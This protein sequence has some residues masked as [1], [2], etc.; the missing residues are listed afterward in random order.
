MSYIVVGVISPMMLQ[1]WDSTSILCFGS[2]VTNF[3]DY[4]SARCAIRRTLRYS[5]RHK[6]GWEE[7][8]KMRPMAIKEYA[9]D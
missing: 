1:H 5:K 4:E 7:W 9:R 6:L 3:P 2:T 8:N